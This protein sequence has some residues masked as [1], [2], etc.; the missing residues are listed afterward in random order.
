MLLETFFTF[1][2]PNAPFCSKHKKIKARVF[3][4]LEK[5]KRCQQH[6]FV[7]YIIFFTFSVEH[8]KH[9]ITSKKCMLFSKPKSPKI[10]ARGSF[11]DG[12]KFSKLSRTIFKR[13][14]SGKTKFGTPPR[15]KFRFLFENPWA[16]V[17]DHVK[18]V[19]NRH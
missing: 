3:P 10:L 5:D 18:C 15:S 16:L 17:V 2:G 7:N 19:D 14:N 9:S 11:R 8:R 12:T 1:I 6:F 4:C 13:Q